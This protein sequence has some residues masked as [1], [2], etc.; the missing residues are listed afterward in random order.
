MNLPFRRHQR[1]AA[2][3]DHDD[4]VD[5][6]PQRRLDPYVLGAVVLVA[7][8]SLVA[9][10]GFRSTLSGWGFAG[11]A[12]IGVAGASGVVLLARHR[13][14]ILGESVALSALAFVVLGGVAVRGVPTPGAYRDFARGLVDGWADLLSAAPPADITVEL[15][16]LPFT[17]AWL[18]A[19]I[20]GEVARHTRRPGLPAI[21]PILALGL[22]LLFTIEDRTI[23]LAQG[24]G[25]VAGT[26][27][28]VAWAQRLGRGVAA[29]V[30]V[31]E[32]DAA[33]VSNN[34]RRLALG[35]VLTA[36]AAIAAPFV[37]PHLP[38]A[39]AHERFDLRQYQSPPFDP[40]LLPSPLTQV[41]A[42]LKENRRE[43]TVFT[44][45]G[46]PVE[47][48]SVA[49]LT[50][51]DGVVWTVADPVRRRGSEA[52]VPVDTELPPLDREV[53]A[54]ST[55]MTHEVEIADLGGYFLPIPGLP[56]R[57]EF[58][59]AEDPDPRE[60]LETGTIAIPTG[61]RAG[62]TY[63]V[64]TQVAPALTDDQRAAATILE[65]PDA[66]EEDDSVLP[67]V[68][69]L[70]ADIVEGRSRG[71]GQVAAIR[72]TLTEEGFYDASDLTVPGH[73]V[74]R[75]AAMLED[76]ARIVG[77]EE[78]YAAAAAAMVQEADLPVRVVVGYLLPE[79]RW[80]GD[81][82]EVRA[83]D[84]SAWIEV[85]AGPLGWIPVDVT[86][87][88]S[89]QPDTESEGSVTQQVAIPNPPPPPPPPPD[90]QPP[91]QEDEDILEERE[92]AEFHVTIEGRGLSTPVKIAIAAGSAPVALLVLFALVVISWKA[93]RRWRR[94]RR[95]SSAA[96]VAG[97]WA[98]AIDRAVESGAPL[99]V[100]TTPR[101]AVDAYL[102]EHERLRPLEPD[103]RQ[104]VAQVDRATF[105]PAPPS[106]DHVEVAWSCSDRVGAELRAGRTLAGRVKMRLDPRPL[107]QDHVTAGSRS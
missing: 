2:P 30:A 72:D 99:L 97:A 49:V 87:D 47:R 5:H 58:P 56:T 83:A 73:A 35:V 18:A 75:L 96:K 55:T 23:A 28:L 91:R 93:L 63:E 20:G 39:D 69:N 101:E 60:N 68:R 59:G 14:L 13:R 61:L 105:A 42:N 27:L 86:P 67:Q 1:D 53:P 57:V 9:A 43:E 74:G 88:R 95:A 19:A 11:S 45:R 15:R 94:Q 33:A 77:F 62:F 10:S 54:T 100:R 51:Y 78:Q 24:G 22:S 29:T 76:P 104:L 103:L 65:D 31:D 3:F 70:T 64:T 52:F 6:R 36:G 81:R 98:E 79:E 40:L 25:L 12:A 34:R 16:A 71:W 37:G 21:G 106:D 8:M 17:V 44:I 82:V 7:I 84:I 48:W 26:L 90:V 92:M 80:E 85:D 102:V 4:D 50:D 46:E 107:R 32:F 41:K 89:R 38:L 66:E